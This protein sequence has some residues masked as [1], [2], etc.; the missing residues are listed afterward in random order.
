MN[1]F[2]VQGSYRPRIVDRE[3]RDRLQGIGAV[4]IEGPRACGKTETA[5]HAAASEALLDVDENLR[6]RSR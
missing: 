4:V 3:L 5:R 1:N 6:Q 2:P